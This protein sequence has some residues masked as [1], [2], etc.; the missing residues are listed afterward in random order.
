[1]PSP[2]IASDVMARWRREELH[3]SLRNLVARVEAERK[4]ATGDD[5]RWGMTKKELAFTAGIAPRTYYR[6]LEGESFP[7]NEKGVDGILRLA[8]AV[9]IDRSE[10]EAY[11]PAPL[12]SSYLAVESGNSEVL[13]EILAGIQENGAQIREL[14]PLLQD[15]RDALTRLA[16]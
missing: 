12:E 1:V 16:P 4:A 8:E 3:A 10:A 9:G 11:L 5:P 13:R 14:M 2:V 7:V 15:I 6:Y